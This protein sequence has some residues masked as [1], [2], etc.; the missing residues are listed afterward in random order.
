MPEFAIVVF[1]TD[2]SN[3]ELKDSSIV[4]LGIFSSEMV[5]MKLFLTKLGIL[6][7]I[8]KNI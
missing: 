7:L 3:N 4:K 8:I 6:I 1:Q 5:E 2:R